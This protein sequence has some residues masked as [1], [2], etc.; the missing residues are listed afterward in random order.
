MQCSCFYHGR[1]VLYHLLQFSTWVL[2]TVK[3]KKWSTS[4]QVEPS[5]PYS[6]LTL[7][8]SHLLLGGGVCTL[9]VPWVFSPHVIGLW[10]QFWSF[11]VRDYKERKFICSSNSY[12]HG[13]K[14]SG[15]VSTILLE[16]SE[17]WQISH[18]LLSVLTDP[19]GD[20]FSL[21]MYQ[22][23][24]ARVN[25]GGLNCISM[26]LCLNSVDFLSEGLALNYF[27]QLQRVLNMP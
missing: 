26:G 22:K 27:W 14:E 10:Q 2:K 6:P 20:C 24:W 4:P 16:T 12:K 1:C 15:A 23:N 21:Q 11:P 7:F 5:L 13:E 19:T 9:S 18:Q 3:V 8:S 17:P 25:G